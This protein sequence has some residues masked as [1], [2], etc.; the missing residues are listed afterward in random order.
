MRSTLLALCLSFAVAAQ[1]KPPAKKKPHPA[2]A[3]PA[4][5]APAAPSAPEAAPAEASPSAA[6]PA[7][8]P[9]P[10][11]APS[12]PA[13][14]AP[15]AP[16]APAPSG[17]AASKGGAIDLDALN[18]E[19]HAL[20]DELFRSRAKA[21]LLG[22]ALFKTK[23]VTSFQYKAQRA[24]PL[25]R[26]TLRLDDQPVYAQ[27]APAAE[28]PIKLYEGFLAPGRHALAVHVEC[29]AIGDTRLGYSAEDTFTFD[30]VDGK[31][32][33]VELLVDETGD[34]PQ[35]LA[36]KKSG[37]FDVRVR[38]RVRSLGLEEK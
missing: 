28:E 12:T 25:K 6:E 13:P 21:E 17:P 20:R 33:R 2:P 26:V 34:G 30:V 11:P 24:W 7:S 27:E 38:A 1:A 31:Q 18:A 8:P 32:A 35:P 22:S 5:P 4:T 10:T 19:Y 29:G 37:D 3:A 23:L 16:S 15:A 36:K 14:A 9:A